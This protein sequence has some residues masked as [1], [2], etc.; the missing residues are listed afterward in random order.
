VTST[1]GPE[2]RRFIDRLTDPITERAREK[3]GQAEDR[4]RASIQAE[5][6]A[7]SASVRTRAV[8]VRPSAIAFAGAAVLTFLGLALLVTAAVIGLAHAV[9][10]WLAALL[11]GVALLL[12]AAGLAAWGRS[13]LPRTPMVDLTRI[14]EPTHPAGEQVHPWAD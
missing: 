9:E 1:P 7:V 12:V 8:Q 14:Q 2:R 11:V 4:V 3:L 13:H 5:I 6:D 10:P